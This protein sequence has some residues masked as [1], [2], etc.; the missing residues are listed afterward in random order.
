M[1]RKNSCRLCSIKNSE[2]SSFSQINNIFLF[3]SVHIVDLILSDMIWNGSGGIIERNWFLDKFSITIIDEEES[4]RIIESDNIG[5][6]ISCEISKRKLIR[7]NIWYISDHLTFFKTTIQIEIEFHKT[8]IIGY[9]HIFIAIIVHIMMG[10]RNNISTCTRSKFRTDRSI[11]P[12]LIC[13]NRSYVYMGDWISEIDHRI[14]LK[15]FGCFTHGIASA[16]R[17]HHTIFIMPSD[18]SSIR[19]RTE[20]IYKIWS[21][22]R[23]I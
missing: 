14:R 18:T 12:F 5:K 16:I 20:R 19:Y 2:F 21:D 17:K 4:S 15:P 7:R 3:I 10:N 9:D 6:T 1:F 22:H 8:I 23:L 13:T 11:D